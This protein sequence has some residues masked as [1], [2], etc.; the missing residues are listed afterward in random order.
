MNHI[1]NLR[2]FEE[3]FMYINNNAF[4]GAKNAGIT[5]QD[6]E[7]FST[8]T[9]PS[10]QNAFTNKDTYGELFGSIFDNEKYEGK[11]SSFAASAQT[12]S[13]SSYN[14]TYE[15]LN[16]LL[17]FVQDNSDTIAQKINDSAI[18]SENENND[19]ISK[20]PAIP[21]NLN[22]SDLAELFKRT[23][24][25]EPE[26]E[27]PDEES[28]TGAFN[29]NSEIEASSQGKIGDCWLLTGLNSLSYTENGKQIIKNSITNNNDGT[30]TVYFK[31]ISDTCS[32]QIP[33]EKL[34][35]ARKSELYSSGDSDV[36]LVEIATETVLTKLQE[37]ELTLPDDAPPLLY[38]EKGN[39]LNGGYP[40]DMVYLLTGQSMEYKNIFNND[41]S[42]IEGE[43]L[44]SF[45]NDLESFYTKFEQ[46]PDSSCGCL[47]IKKNGEQVVVQDVNG[48]DTVLS[49][50][51]NHS[52]SIKSVNENTITFVNPWDSSKEV[53]VEKNVIK[54]HVLGYEYLNV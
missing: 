40:S 2:I 6:G 8:S 21:A 3:R 9:N 48:N 16:S 25:S 23:D 4:F 11:Y 36:L 33:D 26:T 44:E 45:Y 13:G 35:S 22:L 52:L 37:G 14:D 54:E 46:N 34:E 53:T 5:N 10:A 41:G 49:D 42:Y 31:G 50:K 27:T 32:C 30:Y 24:I 47:H 29:I 38:D 12:S 19:C 28:F 43:E 20:K 7:I 15:N 39:P 18:R 51:E 1:S 17:N